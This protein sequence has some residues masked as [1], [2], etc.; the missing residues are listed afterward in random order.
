MAP[1]FAVVLHHTAYYRRQ[2]KLR[3]SVTRYRPPLSP[4]RQALAE[5]SKLKCQVKHLKRAVVEGDV[6]LTKV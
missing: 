3:V 2:C 5:N 4:P 1:I 6:R